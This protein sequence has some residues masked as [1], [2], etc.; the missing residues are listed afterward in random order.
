MKTRLLAIPAL[1]AAAL[2]MSGCGRSADDANVSVLNDVVLND[3]DGADTN[4][5]ATDPLDGNATVANATEASG[6]AR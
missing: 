3:T 6:N 1:I 5:S 2:A 4:L